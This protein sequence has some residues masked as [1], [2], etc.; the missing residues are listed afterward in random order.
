M[1]NALKVVALNS[2]I[3]I[4]QSAVNSNLNI[5]TQVTSQNDYKSLGNISIFLIFGFGMIGTLI[6]TDRSYK[7]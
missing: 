1:T 2:L 4:F 6:G 3:C 7:S 5:I